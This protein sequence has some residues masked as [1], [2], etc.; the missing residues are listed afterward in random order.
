MPYSV[1]L[2]L[3]NAGEQKYETETVRRTAER[4]PD[5]G[6]TSGVNVPPAFTR[7]A[8]GLYESR[9]EA[10]RALGEISQNLRKNV[11]LQVERNEGKRTFLVPAHRVHYVVCDEVTR[12]K[13]QIQEGEV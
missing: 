9:A 10:D 2:W 7:L 12:P 5:S 3:V 6:S 8:Y 4:R 13:D 1:M 11:P